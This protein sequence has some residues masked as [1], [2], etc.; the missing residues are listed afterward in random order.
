MGCAQSKVPQCCRCLCCK[1][2]DQVPSLLDVG[3]ARSTEEVVGGGIAMLNKRHSTS[4]HR[5]KPIEHGGHQ[6]GGPPRH[7]FTAI[8][9]DLGTTFSCVAAWLPEG[10]SGTVGIFDSKD[11]EDTTPSYVAFNATDMLVGSKAKT[12]T[13]LN[14]VRSYCR[15]HC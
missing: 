4:S 7:E 2:Q 9:I 14:A 11:G 10:E 3:I 12:Q 8:G 6:G 15:R 5:Q 1:D 13:G